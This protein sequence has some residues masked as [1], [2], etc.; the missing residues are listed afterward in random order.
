M[1]I[2]RRVLVVL[3]LALGAYL[4]GRAIVELLV[5]DYSNPSSYADDWG[6]PSLAGVL[7]VHAGRGVLALLAFIALWRRSTNRTR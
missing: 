3:G 4:I 2:V 1:T 6:G 7:L 5:I